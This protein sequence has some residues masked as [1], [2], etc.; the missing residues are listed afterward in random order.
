MSVCLINGDAES[1][2]CA[3]SV[4]IKTEIQTKEV[5]IEDK[6]FGSECSFIIS[7]FYMMFVV[8]LTAFAM[9]S[10]GRQNL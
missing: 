1:E 3:E 10:T 4:F 2:Q 8:L 7:S 9:C 5:L 6:L